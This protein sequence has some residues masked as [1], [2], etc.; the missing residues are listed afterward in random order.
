M[1]FV[2]KLLGTLPLRLLHALGGVI[3]RLVYLASPTYRRNLRANLA[4]AF[5]AKR[6]ARLALPVAA[7]AGK[8]V[9]EMPVMWTAPAAQVISLVREVRGWEVVE[10][11]RAAGRGLVFLTPHLGCFEITAQYIATRVPIAVLYRMP[12][13]AWLDRLMRAGRG[14]PGMSSWPA[15]LSGVRALMKSLRRKEA[16]GLLPDQAP[17]AG[18]GAWLPF[19]GRPA[20]TMTLAARLTEATAQAVFVWGERLPRGAGYRLHFSLPRTPLAGDVEQRAAAIN[21]EVEILIRECPVQYLWGYN[22]YKQP[23]GAPPA[24]EQTVGTE[25]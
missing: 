24:P 5:G 2:F 19:F 11:A 7:E 15:D 4:L 8:T 21:R 17:K 25:S 20:Y 22:R 18:E 23:L 1:S 14:R 16:V 3:G 6:A 13:Q 9:F 12:R 10:A